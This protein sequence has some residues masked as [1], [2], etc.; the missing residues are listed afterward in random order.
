MC[1]SDVVNNYFSSSVIA[2]V[3]LGVAMKDAYAQSDHEIIY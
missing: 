3:I 1:L 2:V